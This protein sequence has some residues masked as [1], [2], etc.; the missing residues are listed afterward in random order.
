MHSKGVNVEGRLRDALEGYRPLLGRRLAFEDVDPRSPRLRDAYRTFSDA[1]L[2]L[3][4]APD[5]GEWVDFEG[6]R[7]P[8]LRLVLDEAAWAS[9]R[10]TSASKGYAIAEVELAVRESEGGRLVPSGE[11]AR[12]VGFVGREA[13]DVTE[14]ARIDGELLANGNSPEAW[15]T[16]GRR[17]G[18]LL[19][20]PLCC[21]DH[22][23]RLAADAGNDEVVHAVARGSGRFLPWL[24]N[25]SMSL[26]HAISWFPCRYDCEASAHV[27][28]AVEE[29]VRATVG[30]KHLLVRRYLSMPR[31][32]FDDRRQLIFEGATE[33]NGRVRYRAVHSPFTFDRRRDEV[34]QDWLFHA[35]VVTRLG[36][37]AS[38]EMRGK[39]AV[40]G[41]RNTVETIR[42]TTPPVWMP[43]GLSG[44]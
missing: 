44:W 20:Y 41:S 29:R 28:R 30:R 9:L 6:G 1:S 14:A 32:Y 16:L 18:A 26:Y 37:A 25:V 40:T 7:K 33:R 22:F 21:V 38:F 39:E 35:E 23:V 3:D 24:N 27:A 5:L 8:M 13:K 42:W 17:L 31:L 34:L 10:K 11:R 19:G 12:V 4:V 36:A 43:F 15:R 2:R